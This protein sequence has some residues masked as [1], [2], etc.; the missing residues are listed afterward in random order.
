MTDILIPERGTVAERIRV[1]RNHLAPAELAVANVLVESYP[2]AGLV[3]VMQ[4]AAAAGVSAPTVLRFVGKLGFK[5]YGAFHKAL[6]AEVQA[7]IFSPV[8]VYPGTT[9]GGVGMETTLAQAQTAFL[10]NI[11]STFAHLD[12]R[13]LASAVAALADVARPVLALGG[14]F[15]SV[16]ATQLA[17]YLSM[18][19]GGVHHAAPNSGARIAAMVDAGPE[20]VAV[21]F[22]YRRYQQTSVDWGI[23]AAARGAYLIVITDQYLSPLAPHANSLLTTSTSALDPFDSMTGGFALTELLISEVARTLGTPA[24]KR[25]SVFEKLQQEEEQKRGKIPERRG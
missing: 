10:E 23:E 1:L 18:L 20:T 3:P 2:M 7:R 24:R 17:G 6:R 14:R 9:G 5:G 15:S 19:R 4:L 11:R 25:L 8:D 12:P 21:V 16:L 22:D 13:E